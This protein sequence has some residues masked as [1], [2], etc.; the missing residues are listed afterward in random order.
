MP[1]NTR[2]RLEQSVA[3]RNRLRVVEPAARS[4]NSIRSRDKSSRLH[5]DT[6]APFATQNKQR[7]LSYR[8]SLQGPGSFHR[9]V[10]SWATK[11][12]TAGQGQ[13]ASRCAATFWSGRFLPTAWSSSIWQTAPAVGVRETHPNSRAK[14]R[15]RVAW[16]STEGGMEGVGEAVESNREIIL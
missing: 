5:L 1:Q 9:D 15:K 8:R 11:Q 13:A 10:D 3:R 2:D 14:R 6:E 7:G 16:S 4:C 12:T